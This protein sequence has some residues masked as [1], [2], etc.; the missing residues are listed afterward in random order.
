MEK[1]PLVLSMLVTLFASVAIVSGLQISN[2]NIKTVEFFIGQNTTALASAASNP[3]VF[4]FYLPETS[5]AKRYA[6]IE[7]T[8]VTGG[9]DISIQ[10]DVDNQNVNTYSVDSSG[11]AH[12]IVIRYPF[13]KDITTGTNGPYTLNIKA[14]GSTMSLEAAKLVLTYEYD[15]TSPRQLRTVRYFA[16]QNN[17]TQ[18][19]AANYKSPFSVYFPESGKIDV[20]SAFIE[21][22]GL[23]GPT[24]TTTGTVVV[25]M[26]NG[27]SFGPQTTASL[28]VGAAA[29]SN[30]FSVLYNAS[31]IYSVTSAGTQNYAVN[32]LSTTN[33][34]S[35]WNAQAV[36]TYEYDSN[37]TQQQRTVRYFAGKDNSSLAASAIRQHNFVV[38]IAESSATVRSA[39]FIVSGLVTVDSDVFLNLSN[40]D[41]RGYDVDLGPATAEAGNFF[42]LYNASNLYNGNMTGGITNGPFT[43]NAQVTGSATTTEMAE[44][45]LTYNYSTSDST[46]MK[47]V[48][49]GPYTDKAQRT[50]A[51]A[52]DDLFFI[53]TPETNISTKSVYAISS[54]LSTGTAAH[55]VTAGTEGTIMGHAQGNSGENTWDYVLFNGTNGL[56]NLSKGLNGAFLALRSDSIIASETSGKTIATFFFQ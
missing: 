30:F 6:W 48:E 36:M 28:D 22:M 11:I 17:A 35:V 49:Y 55:T 18:A 53:I 15:S 1:W 4:S 9:A 7:I 13:H 32:M 10:V 40:W 39:Y 52:F 33:P 8:G 43:L 29:A 47:T 37:S 14:T 12:T 54:A 46:F 21:F 26:S 42:I 50:A 31:L 34:S 24:G 41:K 38:P 27:A 19:A 3:F 16:A 20:R 56:Y 44:L 51:A 45:Y 5:V 2:S 25:N 23:S